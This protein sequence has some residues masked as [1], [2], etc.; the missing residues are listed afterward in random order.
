MSSIKLIL[1]EDKITKKGD[2]PIYLRIIKGR[3]PKF[4]S[5]GIKVLPQ[6][7]DEDAQ[8]V[9]KKHPNSARINAYLASKVADA[10]N[11]A[12]QMESSNKYASSTR[13]SEKIRGKSPVGMIAYIKKYIA[14]LK[15]KGKYSTLEKVEVVLKKLETFTGAK[16]ISFEEF[17]LQ[18][19]KSFDT[20]MRDKL[21][22]RIN[23][24][25]ANLKIIRKIFNDAI[26]EELIDY[27][28][29]P[30]LKFQLKWENTKKEYLTD[31]ELDAIERLSLKE[32]S[33]MWHHRNM[34]MFAAYAG[35]IRISDVILLKWS[36]F[37]GTHIHIVTQ[38]TKTTIPIKL[39]TKALS[40]LQI[41]ERLYP[42][43][44]DADFVFPLLVKGKDYDDAYIRAKAISSA[45]AYTNK[46]LKTI[47][48][49]AGLEKKV[50]FHSSRHTFATRALRKGM[51]IEY[52]SSILG[53]S[54]IKTT[55]IYTK[56]VNEELDSAMGVFD[57]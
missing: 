13:I 14:E 48:K 30:F 52:V 21:H 32:G 16:E 28:I 22:N 45:S 56:I 15:S 35:G 4:I 53:H 9:K 2:A 49:T 6:N 51:R 18:F 23:T 43:K 54:E 55:Q 1:K 12:L 3:K 40:I 46:D 26:R 38:K 27:T 25:H 37:N 42:D 39:P 20:Y 24:I 44:M 11:I 7:W 36:S 8:R 29:N 10:E 33:M 57:S 19:L 34:Y 5:T 41:Y 31:S 47:A 17:D 50:S